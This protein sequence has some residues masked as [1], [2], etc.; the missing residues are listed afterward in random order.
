[1]RS[2]KQALLGT[3]MV[4]LPATPVIAQDDATT[5]DLLPGVDLVTEEVER[6]CTG[7]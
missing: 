6:G 2:V 4:G 1:M 7:C 3:V 5:P